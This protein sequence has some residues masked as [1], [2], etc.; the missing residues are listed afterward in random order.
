MTERSYPFEDG[1]G[2]TVTEDQWSYMAS[3]WQDDGIQAP[4]PWDAAL[5]VTSAN[6]SLVLHVAPGHATVGGMH[7]HLDASKTI[8]F[9]SNG[10]ANSRIDRIV[11]KL[12]RVSNTVAFAYKQ[13]TPAASPIAPPVDRS[14]SSPEISICT[15]TVRPGQSAVLPAEVYD[16][17]DFLGR[18]IKVTESASIPRG[19]IAYRPSADRFY[20]QGSSALTEVG[21]AAHNH[22][23]SYAPLGHTHP[24]SPLGHT[25]SMTALIGGVSVS[26]G[27]STPANEIWGWGRFANLILIATPT[28]GT[29]SSGTRIGTINNPALMPTSPV[30]LTAFQDDSSGPYDGAAFIIVD[31]DGDISY[32]GSTEP[33]ISS[34]YINL[35]ATYICAG[36]APW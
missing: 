4:G 31:T 17:R 14:W 1:P 9:A 35:S 3:V 10:A 28:S 30:Y 27:F 5:K 25:H 33:W 13:G 34:R 16:E 29:V 21:K 7:Y 18:Y 12:D 22:D 6:E 36:Y 15:F 32:R 8:A 20:M 2:A 23:S 11:L 19:G 24:Y 26:S